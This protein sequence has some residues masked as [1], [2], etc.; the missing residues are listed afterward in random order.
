[1]EITKDNI[2]VY[3]LDFSEGRLSEEQVAE[4]NLFVL[5]HPEYAEL[6]H[7]S[8]PTLD[9]KFEEQFDKS[10]LRR[11]S[12]SDPSE[13]F[14]KE[15]EGGIT[16]TEK[17]ELHDLLD[18]FPHLHKE[19]T[20]FT[21]TVLEPEQ[22][23]FPHKEQLK[24]RTGVLLPLYPHVLRIAALFIIV[25]SISTI[26]RY[27]FLQEDHKTE[28]AINGV[29]KEIIPSTKKND[30]PFVKQSTIPEQQ[31][32]TVHPATKNTLR[33][34]NKVE[35]QPDLNTSSP[36]APT[37]ENTLAEVPRINKSIEVTI[38][39][40]KLIEPKP[41]IAAV[42]PSV[43]PALIKKDTDHYLTVYDVANRLISKIS[44]GKVD[45]KHDQDQGGAAVT[46]LAVNDGQ[47]EFVRKKFH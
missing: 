33:V 4:L 23:N 41:L 9:N 24:K 39:E 18:H 22:I 47:F 14:I 37:K 36:A 8:L 35:A 6:L 25:L 17:Q 5:L 42:N 7:D 32:A 1:M 34:K 40:T 43:T 3:L 38:P 11:Y 20:L 29:K 13:I 26:V 12:F 16:E 30:V 21:L 15:L 27:Y 45:F 44:R 19:R 31:V 2:E 28:V 46:E 10:S